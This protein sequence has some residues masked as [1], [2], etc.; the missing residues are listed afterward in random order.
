MHDLTK[1]NSF[2][3]S[4]KLTLNGFL[5]QIMGPLCVYTKTIFFETV[6]N[7][8]TTEIEKNNNYSFITII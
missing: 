2:E 8:A 6:I 3:M 5:E 4:I 7:I 1:Q